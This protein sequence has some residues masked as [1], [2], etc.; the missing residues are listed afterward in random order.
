MKT[1]P[2]PGCP[3]A[4][5]DALARELLGQCHAESHHR[6][7][8]AGERLVGCLHCGRDY[9]GMFFKVCTGGWHKGGG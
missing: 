8:K 3:V 2:C 9:P 6:S 7:V 4:R 5:M 1:D